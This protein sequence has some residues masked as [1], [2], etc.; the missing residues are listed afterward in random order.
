MES[1]PEPFPR[2]HSGPTRHVPVPVYGHAVLGPVERL[3]RGWAGEHC[4][5]HYVGQGVVYSLLDRKW[6]QRV[7]FVL[8]GPYQGWLYAYQHW[9]VF[10]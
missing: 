5:G 7:A 8:V 9:D 2:R 4:F 3:Q 10:I 1:A 6:D